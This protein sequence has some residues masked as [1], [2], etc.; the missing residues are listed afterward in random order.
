MSDVIK[1]VS[2]MLLA[3]MDIKVDQLEVVMGKTLG[4]HIDLSEI[5][6]QRTEYEAW[7]L[8]DGIVRDADHSVEQGFG[9]RVTSDGALKPCLLMPEEVD[10]APALRDRNRQATAHAMRSQFLSREER[11]DMIETLSNP[12]G[13]RMQSTGG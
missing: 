4:A 2:Q 3:P 10:M 9:L 6:L 7:V 5:F 12:V 8:E 13:R 11:Y 1:Q